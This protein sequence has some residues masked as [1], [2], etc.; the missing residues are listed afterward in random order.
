MCKK[1]L[2]VAFPKKGSVLGLQQ[3]ALFRK[4]N[5]TSQLSDRPTVGLLGMLILKGGTSGYHSMN[6]ILP[7]SAVTPLVPLSI[8][9]FRY[10]PSSSGSS[11]SA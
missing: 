9:L 11:G 10:S 1:S 4:G 5:D 6:N 2:V 8:P 3:M 7:C